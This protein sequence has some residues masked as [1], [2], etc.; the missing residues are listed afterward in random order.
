M[1]VYV[2]NIFD[3][4]FTKRKTVTD[5][6]EENFQTAI[7]M[8]FLGTG[9]LGL[10]RFRDGRTMTTVVGMIDESG[11][12][13][14]CWEITEAYGGAVKCCEC[15]CGESCASCQCCCESCEC[16]GCTCCCDCED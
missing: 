2:C 12:V 15:G 5:V 8:W 10:W 11:K 14:G 6:T 16:G 1:K 3:G 4:E 13:K 9:S 7:S